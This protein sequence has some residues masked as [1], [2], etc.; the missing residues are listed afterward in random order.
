MSE[1]GRW[2]YDCPD[3]GITDP[4]ARG[5]KRLDDTVGYLWPWAG[6][7]WLSAAFLSVVAMEILLRRLLKDQPLSAGVL[8]GFALANLVLAPMATGAVGH[9]LYELARLVGADWA[10]PYVRTAATLG[11]VLSLTTA[12]ARLAELW[13]LARQKE[14][15]RFLPELERLLLYGFAV[16]IGIF[17]YFIREEHSLTELFVSTGAVAAIVAFAMQR[18]LGDLFSGIALSLERPFRPGDWLTLADGTE[19][20]VTDINWRATRL[21]GWD[22]ATHVIPNSVLAGQGFKNLHGQTHVFAPW[23]L[24][25]I[26]TEVDPRVAKAL[27]LEAALRCKRTVSQTLPIVRLADATTIP[28]TYMIWVHFPNY[29]AMFAGREELFREI[30]Y[31]LKRAGIQVAPE[32]EEIRHRPVDTV[33]VDPPTA[34]IALKGLD[35]ANVL[36]DEEMERIAGMSQR[37]FFDAGTVLV[38]EG[39]ITDAFHILVNGV[40]EASVLLTDGG[41]KVVERLQPGDYFGI[42]SMLANEPANLEFQAV[43]DVT[44]IRV[45]LICLRS[46]LTD[47]PDLADHFAQIVQ[48]RMQLAEDAREAAN[49][50]VRHINLHELV[51]RIEAS[52]GLR[53]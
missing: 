25:R 17:I 10:A 26:P 45:D 18:T 20:Q 36:S 15:G 53:D 44:V 39:A 1:D 28:Y 31:A 37:I 52:L 50:P 14:A 19:G 30:H 11:V 47:R 51:H 46:V 41:R 9:V 22:N 21:R 2:L 29:P 34:L 23:Y 16:L 33:A 38:A 43:S 32:V 4:A 27:L 12:V 49:R 13:L 3:A 40:V 42:T 6:R 48:R 35:L 5:A 24:V 8:W 7:F